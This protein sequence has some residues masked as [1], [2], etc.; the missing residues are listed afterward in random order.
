MKHIIYIFTLLL[1]MALPT[2]AQPPMRQATNEVGT[3]GR[4][5]GDRHGMSSSGDEQHGTNRL[6]WGRDTTSTRGERE[7]P[8]GIFQ[9]RIDPILGTVIP[10]ENN[11]T[12][13]HLY[14]SYNNTAGYNGEYSYLGNVA[15]PRLS[16][17]YLNRDNDEAPFLFLTPFSFA[18]PGLRKLLFSNTLC[19]I[20]NLSYHSVGNSQNGEDRVRAYFATNINKISGYGLKLDY[21]YGRGYYNSSQTSNFGAD[22]FGY[23]RGERYEMHAWVGANH[24]KIAENGGI[25]DDRYIHDPQSFPQK[26]KTNDIPVMLTDAYNRNE[27]Q[28]YHLTHRYNMGF[29]KE[30]PVPDSL[31]PQM[32]SDSELLLGLKDSI[33]QVLDKDSLQRTHVLDSLHIKWKSSQ[34]VPTE[35]VTV[36]SIIHTLSISNLS[37]MHYEGTQIPQ[38][39]YTHNYY[40]MTDKLKDRTDGLRIRNTLGLAMREGFKKWVKMGITAYAAHEYENY[41]M[42]YLLYGPGA[43]DGLSSLTAVGLKQD[44]LRWD[45]AGNFIAPDS[46][47]TKHFSEQ[48]F[49][50]GGEISKHDGKVLHYTVNGEICLLG[51]DIGDFNVDGTGDLNVPLGKK[52]TLSIEAHAFIKNQ[53]PDFYLEHYHSRSTWW[54][55]DLKP[56]FRTRIE[57]TISNPRSH[58]ALRFGVENLKNYAYLGVQKTLL[59]GKN[60]ESLNNTDYSHNIRSLQHNGNIQVLSATLKQDFKLGPLN[61]ENEVTY[62]TTSEPDILPLPAVNVYSNL[63]LLFHIAKVMRVEIGGDIR[64]FTRY[65]APDYAPSVGQFAIQDTANPRIKIGNYPII[66]GYVNAHLKHCRLYFAVNHANAG[67]GRMFLAPHYPINPLTLH[68][69]VS[70]NFFN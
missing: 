23:Y 11:D 44:G 1:L 66:N 42:P 13:V 68:W 69:G 24:Q 8:I 64:F 15:S 17:I 7:I 31:K 53:T 54:D 32:P 49:M 56:V 19:P 20:T 36:S 16:R 14:S 30:L 2:A 33:R 46:L 4:S 3:N 45:E 59:N 40:G 63:Y 34:V 60:P 70:W 5:G 48:H 21:I 61:W 29:Y 67:T 37:H 35:F 18:Q 28:N 58:T 6:S 27:S 41:S 10:S 52:D 55:S 12:V 47:A 26:Y 22:F 38:N 43:P 9:W 50:V 57:G 39:Y 51:D 25:E 65:Y 62:Q